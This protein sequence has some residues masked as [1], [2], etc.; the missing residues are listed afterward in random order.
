VNIYFA[1]ACINSF[2][3]II[4][5]LIDE[6]DFAMDKEIK[7]LEW[8]VKRIKENLEAYTYHFQ[9]AASTNGFYKPI[10]NNYWTNGFWTGEI[11]LAYEK[12]KED[13]F[14]YAALIQVE[15][16]YDRIKEKIGVDHHDMGFLYSLS[17]VA[18]YKLTGSEKGKKAAIMAAEQLMS[19]FHKKGGFIQA[20]GS[21]D[22]PENYRLIIDCLLNV[23]LLY[24]AYDITGNE[25]YKN[26]AGAHTKTALAHVIREDYST[27][28]TFYFEPKTGAPK[29]GETCQGYNNESAWAR[30]QAW[31]VYGTAL[32]FRYTKDEMYIEQFKKVSAFYLSRLPEDLVPYWDLIFSDESDE[33]RDSSSAAIVACGFLEMAKYLPDDEARYY[34]EWARK[35]IDALI[36]GYM[37]VDKTKSNGLL[38]HGTY[39]KSSPYNTCNHRGVDEC[40][41]WG[42]YFFMEA[43]TRL[44]KNWKLYW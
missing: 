13:I 4:T 1:L 6:G 41:S 18:A 38:L 17:C 10:E 12:S 11:W 40:T 31:G 37:A 33:P 2:G 35:M 20:W 7:A 3:D 5:G 16:F 28:H 43:L 39:S 15:S 9:D 29:Y 26:V 27:H 42:D 19:R 34:K 22:E 30:G 14:K 23:P 24:W 25:N 21:M 8:C 36:D 44:T 32:S